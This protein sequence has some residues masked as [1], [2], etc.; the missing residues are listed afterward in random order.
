[1]SILFGLEM[2][3]CLLYDGKENDCTFYILNTC[4]KTNRSSDIKDAARRISDKRQQNEILKLSK[5]PALKLNTDNETNRLQ[6]ST[7]T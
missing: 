4:L 2:W 6:P 3:V 5:T 1:M 7:S